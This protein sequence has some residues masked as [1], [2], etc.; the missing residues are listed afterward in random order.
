[1]PCWPG[2]WENSFALLNADMAARS[3]DLP[4]ESGGLQGHSAALQGALQLGCGGEQVDPAWRP[5][6]CPLKPIQCTKS[7]LRLELEH[8]EVEFVPMLM[9]VN[10][11]VMA[12]R[13]STSLL[14]PLKPG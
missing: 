14:I 11:G 5:H 2:C 8:L 6:P 1:M 4:M 10:V 13:C 7:V 3:G 12:C 9:H